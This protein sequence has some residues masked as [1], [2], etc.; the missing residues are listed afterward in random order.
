MGFHVAD[1]DF[2]VFVQDAVYRSAHGFAD[3]IR[4]FIHELVCQNFQ[5]RQ[6]VLSGPSPG[7]ILHQGQNF[8]GPSPAFGIFQGSG[9][10]DAFQ[11]GNGGI[12][13]TTI[14]G[15]LS[16]LYSIAAIIAA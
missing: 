12:H 14:I 16:S 10:N 2:V 13:R 3:C 15:H 6:V 9:M 5:G 11:V 4:A 7:D 8:L 1:K